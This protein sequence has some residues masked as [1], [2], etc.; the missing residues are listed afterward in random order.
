MS[1]NNSLNVNNVGNSSTWI[2]TYFVYQGQIDITGK[3]I[4][5]T[6]D[7]FEIKNKIIQLIKDIHNITVSYA[8]VEIQSI[9]PSFTAM[10]SIVEELRSTPY[11]AT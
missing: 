2:I 1:I 4:V 10:L 9:N 7:Q 6:Q 11:N 5:D 3:M 8:F